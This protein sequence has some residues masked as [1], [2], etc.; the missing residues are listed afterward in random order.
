MIKIFRFLII[1]MLVSF[2]AQAADLSGEALAKRTHQEFI[3]DFIVKQL[4]AF[5]GEA[6]TFYTY[7]Q[8]ACL[9]DSDENWNDVK[10]QF[11]YTVNA[12]MPLQSMRFDAFE[13][14]S[15]DLRIY[16]WPNSRGEKQ[17]GKFLR[18]LNASKLEPSYFHNLSVALQGLPI[19]E[20]LLYHKDS[21]LAAQ[22]IELRLYTCDFLLAI[23][24]N[25]P[26]VAAELIAEFDVG[27]AAREALLNPSADND[28]YGEQPEVTLQFYK[29]IH[30][31]VELTHGQKLSR[32]IGRELQYLKPKRLEMWRSGLSKQNMYENIAAA[33]D[34]YAIFSPMI[35]Q[36]E[37][38]QQIDQEIADLFDASLKKIDLLPDDFYA[39][40]SDT[41]HKQVWLQARDLIDQLGILKD[42]LGVKGTGALGIP[43]GFNAL[44]GD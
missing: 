24:L 41:E 38:G 32:P 40:L 23:G 28:L 10:T 26:T 17:A 30:A 13:K 5:K 34:M 39:E 18:G 25:L 1:I 36:A 21:T 29:A 42:T 14:N 43:L 2:T 9:T 6:D 15:R 20:W 44:D 4:Q 33:F 35:K 3:D 19:V 37:N 16:F 31:M 27:G 12:W 7:T 11:S 22:D 8:K